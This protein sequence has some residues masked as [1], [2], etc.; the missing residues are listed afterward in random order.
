MKQTFLFLL[1]FFIGFVVNAEVSKTVN[2]TTPG[3]LSTL[4]TSEEKTSVTNLTISGF[5]DA[6]DFKTMRDEMTVL[7]VLDLTNVQIASYTGE[8]GTRL[9][10][11]SYM[12][13]AIPSDAFFLKSGLKTIRLPLLNSTS[14]GESAFV[15]CRGLTTFPFD[16]INSI[17]INAFSGCS[18]LTS[19]IIPSSVNSIGRCAFIFCS[20]LTSVTIPS[21]I[22][23]ID[24]NLFG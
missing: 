24:S 14:I 18:G 21:V 5:I 23:S 11:L 1:L 16:R 9:G 12:S 6:R 8:F 15:Q 7:E 13:N 2:L 4:L 10:S 17:G 3:G 22:N 19:V 20:G